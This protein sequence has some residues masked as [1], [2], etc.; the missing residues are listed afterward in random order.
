MVFEISKHAH[1]RMR[2]RDIP[3]PH[4]VSLRVAK[5]KAKKLIVK[6]CKKHGYDNSYLYMRTNDRD[7]SSRI[8][9]V[10]KVIGLRHYKVITAFHLQY[11]LIQ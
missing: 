4:K 10:C 7:L 2:E 1:D 8:V 3:D 11:D 6:Q 9:Y 5:K